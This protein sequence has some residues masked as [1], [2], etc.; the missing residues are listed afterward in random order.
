MVQKDLLGLLERFSNSE[1]VS[2]KSD[3]GKLCKLII[4]EIYIFALISSLGVGILRNLFTDDSCRL[5]AEIY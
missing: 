3:F 4:L 1:K 2:R 5:R